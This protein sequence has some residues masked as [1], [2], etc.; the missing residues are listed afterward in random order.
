MDSLAFLER[1][2][3]LVAGHLFVDTSAPSLGVTGFVEHV[4]V[5]G[6]VGLCLYGVATISRLLKILGL[7]YRISSLS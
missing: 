2:Q 3:L 1:I 4:V 5:D 6:F 7:F